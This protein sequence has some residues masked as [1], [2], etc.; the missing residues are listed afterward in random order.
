MDA[1]FEQFL[2]GYVCQCVSLVKTASAV[3]VKSRA[4]GAWINPS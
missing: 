1:S 2:H 4:A 3:S